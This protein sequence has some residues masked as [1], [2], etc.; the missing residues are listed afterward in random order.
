MPL[1]NFRLRRNSK[2][3]SRAASQLGDRDKS[4]GLGY[5]GLKDLTN[6]I[7]TFNQVVNLDG[8][9]TYGLYS[10]GEAY[11][12]SGTKKEEKKTTTC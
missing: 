3:G 4:A 10:L 11:Y 1:V 12:A 2:N 5:R 9:N 8:R 7:A 6:A